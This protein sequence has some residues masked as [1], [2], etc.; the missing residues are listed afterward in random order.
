[1]EGTASI[2]SSDEGQRADRLLT[3][4]Y[5]LLKRGFDLFIKL[6]GQAANRVFLKIVPSSDADRRHHPA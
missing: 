2:V 4:K 3:R 6:R 1:M 5:G